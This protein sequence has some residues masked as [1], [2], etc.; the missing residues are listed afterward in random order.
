MDCLGRRRRSGRI[1]RDDATRE[2]GP[3]RRVAQGDRLPR[4]ELRLRR[5]PV[6]GVSG[7][8]SC[9]DYSLRLKTELDA[10]R[11]WVNAYSNDFACYIPSERLVKEGGYGGGAET[12]YFAL[13]ATLREGLEQRIIDEVRR[14]AGG[15]FDR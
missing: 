7:R 6:H 2:A 1:Q 3:R 5:P 15:V 12:P 4:P 9:V 8:R 11:L 13:P 14:Q 10:Q